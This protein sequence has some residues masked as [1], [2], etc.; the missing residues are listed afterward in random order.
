MILDLCDGKKPPK[1]WRGGKKSLKL[2]DVFKHISLVFLHVWPCHIFLQGNR[3]L[4]TDHIYF[5]IAAFSKLHP[6]LKSK[7]DLRFCKQLT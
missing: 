2:L 7:A 5:S 3:R 6:G 1:I 4:Q